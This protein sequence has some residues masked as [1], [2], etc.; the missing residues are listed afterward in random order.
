M[1]HTRRVES[2]V[3]FT[4]GSPFPIHISLHHDEVTVT[5][6]GATREGWDVAEVLQEVSESEHKEYVHT[7]SAFEHLVRPITSLLKS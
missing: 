6:W 2:S 1:D 7:A 3:P 4:H 5:G